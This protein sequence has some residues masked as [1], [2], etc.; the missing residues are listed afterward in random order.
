V[1]ARA[2]VGLAVVALACALGTARAAPSE[3]C[4]G[5]CADAPAVACGGQADCDGGGCVFA[6]A[7]LPGLA[8]LIAEV[9]PEGPGGLN[10]PAR[11]W[12]CGL[13]ECA[14]DGDTLSFSSDY[15]ITAIATKDI[16]LTPGKRYL[17]I[18][19]MKAEPG[20]WGYFDIA[21]ADVGG[22]SGPAFAADFSRVSAYFSVPGEHF[23]P[24]QFRL[25]ADGPG[26]VSIRRIALLELVDYGVWLRFAIDRPVPARFSTGF[27][28]RHAGDGPG[29]YPQPCAPDDDPAICIDPALT[30]VDAAAGAPS[31]WVEVSRM[32]GPSP[33]GWRVT[34]PWH[35]TDPDGAPLDDVMVTAEVAFAPDDEAIVWR[36]QRR[37]ARIGLVLPE[38]IPGPPDLARIPGFVGDAVAADRAAFRPA[39]VAPEHFRVATFVNTVDLFDDAP[40]FGEEGLRLLDALGL[41]SAAFFTDVPGAAERALAVELGLDYRF[42]H[43]EGLLGTIPSAAVDFDR[44][45]L[46]AAIDSA[47]ADPYWDRE[48]GD[49]PDPE[50][51]FLVLGDEIGGVHLAGPAYRA[52]YIAWLGDHDV[53]PADLGLASLDEAE[54]LEAMGW[55]RVPEVR[56]DPSDAAAARRYVWALR[57]WNE[58]TAEIYA[59]GR[60]AL[61]ERYGAM[62]ASFN[63][64]TP[65]GALYFQRVLGAD[66]QAMARAKAVTGFL[67]EGFLGYLDDCFAWQLGA[68][69]DYAA[70]ITAPWR[71]AAA[72]R[73]ESFPLASYLHAYRGDQGAKMLELAARGF[74]WM[75]H[76]AYGPFDLSTGD[77]VG[78]LG[79]ASVPWLERV[80]DGNELLARAEPLLWGAEREPSP[81]V[82]LASQTDSVWSDEPG[83]TNEEIGWHIAFTQA[84]L[85]VDFMLE[86]EIAQGLLESPLT[87]RQVLVVMREHVSRAA[88]AAIQRWVEGGGVLILG[89]GLAAKDEFGQ[90]DTARAEWQLFVASDAADAAREEIRWATSSG[91]SSFSYNGAL[92]SIASIIGG[93][94][95]RTDDERSVAVRVPRGRGLIIA[96]G[97]ALG[98]SYRVPET[99]CDGSRPAVV[100]R[101]PTDFSPVIRQAMTGLVAAAGLSAPLRSESAEVALHRLRGPGG[102]PLVLA[103]PWSNEPLSFAL[104]IPDASRCEQI[105]DALSGDELPLTFGSVLVTLE[106]PALFTWNRAQCRPDVD[107]PSPEIVEPEPKPRDEG[108]AGGGVGVLALLFVITRRRTPR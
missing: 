87:P 13:L 86:D 4:P 36:G 45:A 27:I 49:D 10:D 30:T 88:W 85:P 20:A 98:E 28:L 64:G 50:A 83:L 17:A 63:A 74:Q 73:G 29:F 15:G 37:G 76:Y 40:G 2:T 69:A 78:G 11:G 55:W 57:F 96:L 39:A 33:L 93:S 35:V 67:G 72:A 56:P 61:V 34:I 44:D 38:G 58:A 65:L 3:V 47:L 104:T 26:A 23:G 22:T 99:T 24:I 80:R 52:E 89:G 68:Y 101:R 79:P 60:A 66:Y 95:G 75:S 94:I 21:A 108:C 71:E 43:A 53:A 90:L 14:P 12:T 51:R 1:T 16:A 91:A 81:L 8:R 82:M 102:E 46:R 6:D 59:L 97:L 25:H 32:F 106:G 48:L 100:S 31:P 5:T 103:I 54:P 62:P 84:H 107:E 18:A 92:R 105:E 7:C 41:D 9:V 70:G 19:E 77:G 42:I